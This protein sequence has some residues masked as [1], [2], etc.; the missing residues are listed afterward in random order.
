MLV[1]KES[2]SFFSKTLFNLLLLSLLSFFALFL[3]ILY[4]NVRLYYDYTNLKNEPIP[5]TDEK[6]Y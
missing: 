6:L 1:C 2:P 3:S 4:G 5:E